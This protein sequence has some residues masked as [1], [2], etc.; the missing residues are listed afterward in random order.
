MRYGPLCSVEEFV[1]KRYP[2]FIPYL[3]SFMVYPRPDIFVIIAPGYGMDCLGIEPLWR[4]IFGTNPHRPRSPP[5]SCTMTTFSSSGGKAVEVR[6]LSPTIFRAGVE[7]GSVPG[8][9]KTALTF[10]QVRATLDFFRITL[11]YIYISS[12]IRIPLL[13]SI[14]HI[15]H[16]IFNYR[17]DQL[18]LAKALKHR[19]VFAHSLY[20]C[21]TE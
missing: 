2:I 20:R 18:S 4:Q 7:Y 15:Q 19:P 10:I 12:S 16:R 1:T 21:M 9:H 11:F 14:I 13:F 17:F 8:C 5:N 6:R 3:R